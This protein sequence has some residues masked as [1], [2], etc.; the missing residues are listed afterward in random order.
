[1]LKRILSIILVL[2]MLLTMSVTALASKADGRIVPY[3]HYDYNNPN[4]YDQGWTDAGFEFYV[5]ATMLS[6][7]T[8]FRPEQMYV[9]EQNPPDFMWPNNDKAD[10]YDL[11]VCSDE[12]LEN[13]VYKKE[14]IPT[15]FYNFEH[16][17]ETGV[18]YWWSV[19][20]NENGKDG[21][22]S[23]SRRFRIQPDAYEFTVPDLDTLMSRI[24]KEHPRVYTTK[25]EL[26]NFRT[27][28]D[29]D[30][31]A[32]AIKKFY[33]EFAEA[34]IQKELNIPDNIPDLT[35][36]EKLADPAWGNKI[37]QRAADA[38]SPAIKLAFAYLLTGD[39][40]YARRAIDVMV[41]CSK[42]DTYGATSY[43]NQDQIHRE[44]MLN[45]AVG[46]DW[47]WDVATESER[48][49]I[50]DH[51]L[52][53]MDDMEY[54][55]GQ[56][57][58]IPYDSHGW[59]AYGYIGVAGVALYGETPRA[60][61]W[62][63]EIIPSYI[64][65]LPPWSNQDGGWGQGTSYWKYSSQTNR[66]P[67]DV[68]KRAG[69]IDLYQKTWQKNEYLW[70]LYAASP[71]SYGTFGDQSTDNNIQGPYSQYYHEL[72]YGIA[73]NVDD[74]EIAGVSRWLADHYGYNNNEMQMYLNTEGAKVDTIVPV[75][76]PLSHEFSDI[77]WVVMTDD[78]VSK[79]KIQLTMKSSFFGSFNHSHPDQ[80]S[81][82]IQAYGEELATK[83]GYYDAYHTAHDSGFTRKTGAHNTITVATNKGQK[84][85]SVTAK[86][87]ITAFLNHTDFDLATG[88]ASMAYPL[89]LDYAER[90]IIYIRPDIFV[91]IDDLDS[92][93][94][95]EEKYEW[96]LNSEVDM[97]VYDGGELAGC[98]MTN[99]AAILDTM[100]QYP[101]DI[102]TYYN[103]TFALSD[104][105]T[106]NPTGSFASSPVQ[107]R[108]WFETEPLD[109]TKMIVTMDV[110]RAGTQARYVDTQYFDEYVKMTFE[111][112]TVLYVNTNA[113]ESK[114]VVAGNITFTGA[115]VA[116]RDESIMLVSGTYL[117]EG[118]TEL[119]KCDEIASVVVGRDEIGISTIVDNVISINSKSDYI[120][121]IS[122][123]RDD[124]GN[125][126]SSAW[127]IEIANNGEFA[128]FKCQADNYSLLANGKE[129]VT[130][131]SVAA[132]VTVMVDGVE[133][134]NTEISGYTRRDGTSLYTGKVTVPYGKYE[135]VTIPEG[136]SYGGY[137]EGQTTYL[138]S[139]DVTTTNAQN[140][141]E[142]R[143]V[144]SVVA[145]IKGQGGG[146]T[147]D[148]LKDKL[149]VMVEAEDATEFPQGA[150][151][152]STRAF[153]SN[154][155]G[156]QLHN[157]VGESA[158]YTLNV[159]EAGYYDIAV[160]YVAWEKEIT[161]RG[162]AINGSNYVL[163]LPQTVDYGAL[164]ENWKYVIGDNNIYL[165]PGSYVLAVEA[166]EGMW[167]YDYLGL[168]KR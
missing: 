168:V 152:Y 37:W 20:F 24:P 42:W 124:K 27:L 54:L 109:E 61:K 104:M 126:M 122:D 60:E 63:K 151:I 118:D 9:S 38:Y 6:P 13:I 92:Y 75:D 84:D 127:G 114:Q 86:G 119:I 44:I 18:N 50:I 95:K 36:E 139:V 11:I 88:D 135:V 81:F 128:E 43:K 138:D 147:V 125:L 56:I 94:E 47:C 19:R 155:K 49:T 1:M 150:A 133:S 108:V 68:F 59:T 159:K 111:D 145:G 107:R 162:F 115:A 161:E 29:S 83:S 163:A 22:W 164:P 52:K 57:R 137:V 112:G 80:N 69:I 90:H 167:N 102:T 160:K 157:T 89:T 26:E 15:N 67:M 140:V 134:A 120:N 28:A 64:A 53:R 121:G 30:S 74:P 23:D 91:V 136:A 143:S 48:K 31:N 87:A 96:W 76:Y 165:E 131:T 5:P 85:D 8:P 71:T 10:Y 14:K 73:A 21:G 2:C 156:V 39:E 79:D 166:M 25:A 32:A 55:V 101:K 4:I 103:N 16:T 146:V 106:I 116:Y 62:L 72:L 129:I 70:A 153:L 142:L 66:D 82:I 117:K 58:K 149:A 141:I 12:N 41:A 154:G 158:Y 113:D 144:S 33:V 132:N 7:H 65:F 46:I 98:R 3:P 100:V 45:F 17:F 40:R 93:E 110:H 35:P 130:D 99:G 123:V 148:E 77:G 51:V 78:L 97:E 34:E 105:I